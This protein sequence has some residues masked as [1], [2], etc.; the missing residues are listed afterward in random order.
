MLRSYDD[1]ESRLDELWW[2]LRSRVLTD[3]EM[4]EV[5][6]ARERLVI[7]IGVLYSQADVEKRFNEGLLQQFR[8]I[9]AER[10]EGVE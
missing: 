4:A 5:E 2:A 9:L 6:R 10:R 3:D 7:R 8:L 1:Y